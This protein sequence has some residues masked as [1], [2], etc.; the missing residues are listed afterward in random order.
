ML[1]EGSVY[2]LQKTKLNKNELTRIFIVRVFPPQFFFSSIFCEEKQ[3]LEHTRLEEKKDTSAAAFLTT[4]WIKSCYV[5]V[6][7]DVD[8][9]NGP[10]SKL[11]CEH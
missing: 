3:E 5:Y 10:M 2:F 4:V 9:N 8:P 7:L 1:Q 11:L 6:D